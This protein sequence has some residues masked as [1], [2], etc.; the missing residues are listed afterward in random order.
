MMT[1]AVRLSASAD[2]PVDTHRGA[3]KQSD[4]DIFAEQVG[5][6]RRRLYTRA[7]FLTQDAHAADD[8]VQAVC[9]KALV[10][11]ASFQ[12]ASNLEAWL[13]RIM[14][15]LFID[16]CRS[17]RSLAALNADVEEVPWTQ[18]PSEELLA[19]VALLEWEDVVRGF[20]ELSPADRRILRLAH[21]EGRS[22]RDIAELMGV[23]P[24][25]TGTRLFR[26]RARLRRVLEV[27]YRSRLP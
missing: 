1:K 6:M 23:A 22:Y 19:P 27:V 26:A 18:V 16:L 9:E 20:D 25:T 10:A 3:G 4:D 14:Y 2:N 13:Y 5:G 12:R 24:S 7:V 11:R 15:N 21:V 17:R 8:L